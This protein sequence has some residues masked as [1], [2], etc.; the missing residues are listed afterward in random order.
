MSTT[1]PA[2]DQSHRNQTEVE[3]PDER[4]P[5]GEPPA[6]IEVSLRRVDALD[7]YEALVLLQNSEI[8]TEDVAPDDLSPRVERLRKAMDATESLCGLPDKQSVSITVA[9]TGAE[10]A[11]IVLAHAVAAVHY[12]SE[13]CPDTAVVYER[14]AAALLNKIF[15]HVEAA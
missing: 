3:P 10:A 8:M 12:R 5:Q 2:A 15:A 7:H 9:L 14:G 11:T 4:D 13:G 1:T 6:L